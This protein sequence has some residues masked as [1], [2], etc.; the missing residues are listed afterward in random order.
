MRCRATIGTRRRAIVPWPETRAGIDFARG[1]RFTST[2]YFGCGTAVEP[3][4]VDVVTGVLDP[5]ATMV[6]TDSL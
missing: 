2:T 6:V 4:D 5:G 3:G 1:E